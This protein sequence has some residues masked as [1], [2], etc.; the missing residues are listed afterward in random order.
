MTKT[1]AEIQKAYRER[2]KATKGAEYMKKEARRVQKY[3]IPTDQLLKNKL[4]KYR[5]KIKNAMRKNRESMRKQQ[6]HEQGNNNIENDNS[7]N[8]MT[9]NEPEQRDIINGENGP[10]DSTTTMDLTRTS[11][12][13]IPTTN[14]LTVKMDFHTCK[15]KGRKKKSNE[16]KKAEFKIQQLT[17]SLYNVRKKNN[18]LRTKLSRLNKEK[19]N[20]S[21]EKNYVPEDMPGTSKLPEETPTERSETEHTPRSRTKQFLRSGGLSPRKHKSIVKKLQLHEAMVDDLKNATDSAAVLVCGHAAKRSR[22]LSAVCETMNVD[23]RKL[24]RKKRGPTEI[25]KRKLAEKCRIKRTVKHFME[26]DDNSACLP[27]KADCTKTENGKQQKR[28]LSD[29]L[30]NLHVKFRSEYPDIRI[31]L[32]TF[33]SYR[34]TNIK[35]VHYSSRKTCLCQKHQNMALKVK[36]LRTAGITN[37][38]TPDAYIR[39][40]TNDELISQIEVMIVRVSSIQSGRG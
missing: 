18:V 16:L 32:S 36:G 24:M 40:A 26:R 1:R 9:V 4:M 31:N 37:V 8:Q 11:S 10:C 12:L 29:L 7:Y 17:E 3:Y 33:G 20:K 19:V 2:Q 27:G 35:L 39:L 6:Q 25:Q 13:Q 21:A 15:S 23:T 14:K 22:Q 38:T 34:P 5:N 28:V 30:C